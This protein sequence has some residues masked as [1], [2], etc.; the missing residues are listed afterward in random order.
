VLT[1]VLAAY[2]VMSLVAVALYAADKRR[3]ARGE[4][5]VSE[6]TLHLVAL[7][8]GWPGAWIAQQTLRHKRQKRAFMIV[9]WIIVAAHG[10]AWWWAGAR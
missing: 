7:L 6:T 1:L 3:A 2:A 9:F 8:G 4:W 5:R 10:A